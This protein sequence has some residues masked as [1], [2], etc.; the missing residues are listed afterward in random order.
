MNTQVY[1]TEYD[2]TDPAVSEVTL[3]SHSYKLY[4][5]SYKFLLLFFWDQHHAGHRKLP[6]MVIARSVYSFTL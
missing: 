2:K 5:Y 4:Q 6:Y 3:V 1:I